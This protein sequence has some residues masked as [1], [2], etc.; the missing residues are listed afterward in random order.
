MAISQNFP[1]E[2]PSLALNFA[3]TKKLDPRITFSRNSTATYLN[4][5]GLLTTAPANTPRFDHSYN[6]ST[7]ESLGLLIEE[8]VVNY[9]TYSEDSSNYNF[10][11][12]A[13]ITTNVGT[14]PDGTTTADRI[15]S[16]ING[17]ANTAFV[18]KAFTVPVDSARYI[19]SVFLKPGT[20]PLTTINLQFGGGTYVQSVLTI[21]WSTLSFSYTAGEM[22]TL[23]RYPNG[24]YRLSLSL[25]NNGTN[26][27]C[28]P[29]IYVRDQGSSNVNGHYVDAWGWQVEKAVNFSASKY[30]TSYIPNLTTGSTTRATDY[31]YIGGDPFL[32]TINR[33]EGTIL[34]KARFNAIPLTGLQNRTTA[35]LVG[36]GVGFLWQM[37]WDATQAGAWLQYNA[38]TA[39][40]EVVIPTVG[41]PNVRSI[42]TY[43][44]SNS[45]A[46]KLIG[47]Y[48]VNDFAFCQDG[49][50][51]TT[52]TSGALFSLDVFVI[53][54]LNLQHQLNGTIEQILYYPK[55][56]PDSQLQ[57][58]TR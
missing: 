19:F 15:T 18:Q 46:Y 13:S 22:G 21:T 30:P 2:G 41:D 7:L 20:S 16:T 29:R 3:Q 1:D 25:A 38:S 48:K 56:L 33:T 51:V 34:S 17:G 44:E 5:N 6:G 45:K 42:S 43:S 26:N 12:N 39:T 28:S 52:D 36:N 40:Y 32:K 8:S 23:V 14:A 58:L 10:I 54:D 35:T 49:G 27:T 53:G 31:A 24:W 55:R 37:S 57:Q 9:V 50:P 47:A 11:D 4:A